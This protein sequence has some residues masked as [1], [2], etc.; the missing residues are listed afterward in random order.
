MASKAGQ[1][2][3]RQAHI[4]I[5]EGRIK[6][7]RSSLAIEKSDAQKKLLRDNIAHAQETLKSLKAQACKLCDDKGT[8]NGHSCTICGS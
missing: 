8:V 7:W 1:R 2:M 4:R 3:L 6:D 5:L